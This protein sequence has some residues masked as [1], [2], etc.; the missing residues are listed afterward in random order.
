[1]ACRRLRPRIEFL[2]PEQKGKGS[3]SLRD[4]IEGYE[5]EHSKY[6]ELIK[7]KIAKAEQ[8]RKEKASAY[9]QLFLWFLF[10]SHLLFVVEIL[11]ARKILGF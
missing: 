3:S 4:V 1:M 2:T 8:K 9:I 7:T 10:C 6:E 11:I 5:G